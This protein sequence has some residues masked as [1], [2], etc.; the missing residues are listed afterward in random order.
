MK[1]EM[2]T[3]AFSKQVGKEVF[4]ILLIGFF[5]V[6]SYF[7]NFVS[8]RAV[9]GEDYCDANNFFH[10]KQG[11][12]NT[13]AGGCDKIKGCC[14]TLNDDCCTEENS[15]DAECGE[16]LICVDDFCKDINETEATPNIAEEKAGNKLQ[17]TSLTNCQ[18]LNETECNQKETEGV[19]VAIM[20]EEIIPAREEIISGKGCEKPKTVIIPE[21]RREVYDSCTKN[22]TLIE[23]E[24]SETEEV[25]GF[26]YLIKNGRFDEK[27]DVLFISFNISEKQFNE[28]IN[29]V[30]Y[31][32]GKET[33]NVCGNIYSR[34][35]FEVEPFKQM[36]NKFN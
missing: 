18:E 23:S 29:N 26:K 36:S 1:K 32:K 9:D 20:R 17:R 35:L 11:G 28:S 7:G 22:G 16:N 19:C 34:G 6:F 24:T 8:V 25:L 4:I 10:L 33:E 15:D 2:H 30:L 12:T 5:L 27:L 31:A 13:C 3:S 21:N 14:G